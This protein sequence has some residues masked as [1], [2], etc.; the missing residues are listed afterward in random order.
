L[1]DIKKFITKN[2]LHFLNRDKNT[3]FLRAYGLLPKDVKKI[4]M[5]LKPQDYVGGP[6]KDHNEKYE[7]D[8]WKFKNNTY[9]D[10]VIYIK[11]RYNPPKEVVCISLHEDE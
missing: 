2:G 1:K 10:I 7:G 8:V 4:I 5:S 11:I 6:E 9:M 3:K